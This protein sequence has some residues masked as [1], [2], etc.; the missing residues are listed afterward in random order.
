LLKNSKNNNSINASH[1]FLMNSNT[2]N[3]K[4]NI[5]NQPLNI[6]IKKNDDINDTNAEENYQDLI[7]DKLNRSKILMMKVFFI[8]TI[9]L[10]ILILFFNFFII[11]E[12]SNF[13]NLH[14]LFF[15]D[16]FI[17]TNRYNSFILF[18]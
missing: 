12:F 11:Y 8:I 4:K 17:I 6:H 15:N 1:D 3:S 2:N 13:V 5:K 9:L 10:L 7:L 14:T 16:F 18:L